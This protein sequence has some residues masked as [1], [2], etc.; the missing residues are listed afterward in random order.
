MQKLV[1][2]RTKREG[3]TPVPQPG[4]QRP[5]DADW[6]RDRMRDYG[7]DRTA[8]ATALGGGGNAVWKSLIGQRG[9]PLDEVAIWARILDAPYLEIVRRLGF[10]VA[11]HTVPVT[12]T[13]QAN[14]RITLRH[15]ADVYR[16]PSPPD[17]A[18]N[19]VAC[20]VESAHAAL[21][22]FQ[23]SHFFYEPSPQVAIDAAGRLSVVELADHGSTPV[24]GLLTRG[25]QR[26]V[27]IA[28]VGGQEVIESQQLV[29][30]W[31]IRWQK[32][33]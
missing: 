14:G 19:A 23:D 18:S 3:A 8:A 28:V 20:L 11:D 2:S 5:P 7:I 9:V 33:G 29:A 16:I 10:D 17:L 31:P 4:A 15:P 30:A 25:T 13:L 6:F 26:H 27:R 24:V 32:M 1:K 22:M 12:G 21:F